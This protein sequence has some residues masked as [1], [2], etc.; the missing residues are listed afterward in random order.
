MGISVTILGSNSAIPTTERRPTAQIVD[1]NQDYTLVDCGEGTQIQLRKYGIKFQRISR[2]LISHMH[3]DHYFGLIG[4][5]NTMHLLCREKDL[6]IY[7]PAPLQK[8]INIQLEAAHSKLR[9]NVIYHELSMGNCGVICESKQV[10]I[11]STPVKHRIDC[12]GFVFQEKSHGINIRKEAIQQHN[13]TLEEILQVKAGKDV[14]RES[15]ELLK[16]KELIVDPAPLAKYSF[17]SDTKPNPSYLDAIQDS[18]LLY[19]EATFMND[20]SKR[21]N[22]TFHSTTTQA[23]DVA[24]KANCKRLIIGHFSS[25]YHSLEPLLNEARQTFKNTELA[26][27]GAVFNV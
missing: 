4:L 26:V 21:A 10:D 6:H 24:L 18:D 19:H 9:F 20:M 13:L 14:I 11:S 27:E 8:I 5:L 17:I 22:E 2:I 12:F 23:A 7:A 16:N 1:V 3:G 25:R 15:G